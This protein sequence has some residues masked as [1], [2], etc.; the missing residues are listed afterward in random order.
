[1]AVSDELRDSAWL[2][3]LEQQL[4]L[5]CSMG[6]SAPLY[7]RYPF[8]RGVA[9]SRCAPDPIGR[10]GSCLIHQ[11]IVDEPA[12]LE[13]LADACPLPDSLFRTAWVDRLPF[14][15]PL[16]ALEMSSLESA[17]EREVCHD[18]LRA[19]FDGSEAL[20]TR[21]LRAL[22]LAARDKRYSINVLL[23]GDAALVSQTGRRLMELTLRYLPREDALRLSYCTLP[24][25]G[26]AVQR[27]VCFFPEGDAHLADSADP[28]VIFLD[29]TEGRLTVPRDALLPD[30]AP[31]AA[32]AHTMLAQEENQ[33]KQS[34]DN[35]LS[36]SIPPFE[37]G[38]SLLQYFEDWRNELELRRTSLT[39]EGFR[40]F[41]EKEY[42][43][44]LGSMVEASEVMDNLAFLSEMSDILS[45]IQ[46][47][48]LE[49]SLALPEEILSD[50]IAL[51]LESVRWRRL[52]LSD[53]GTA[54]VLRTVVA[55]AGSLQEEEDNLACLAAARA[56]GHV[57]SGSGSLQNALYDMATLSERFPT[58]F[59]E[60]QECLRG[61]VLSRLHSEMDIIDETLVSAAMLGYARFSDGVPD[62]R[63]LDKLSERIAAK[64]GPRSA[65][66]FLNLLDRLRR[67]LHSARSSAV[68]RREI[69]ITLLICSLLALLIAGINIGYLL[70][71]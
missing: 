56:A 64:S 35:A 15:S 41:A 21:F 49:L 61:Y 24:P 3:L 33:G 58:R 57:L 16:P 59:E 18:T 2:P 66:R 25:A 68:R 28:Q 37:K 71:G 48:N 39:A 52:D 67:R 51:L 32:L 45:I 47:G 8:G 7:F 69:K 62:L 42:P 11:L 23:K 6:L 63:L 65:R 53:P 19:C 46:K 44:L 60:L 50:M 38:M 26:D 10:H 22:S 4:P 30:E 70:L 27:S 9:I 13:T 5:Y 34:A 55:Y 40:V 12:D 29:L 36:I 31:Y 43:P 54:R 14:P 20:L 17:L 1:M